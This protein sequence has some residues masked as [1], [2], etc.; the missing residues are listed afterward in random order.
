M[1]TARLVLK[2]ERDKSI[3]RGH[4]WIYSGAIASEPPKAA[5]GATVIVEDAHGQPLGL[6]AYAPASALRARMWSRNVERPIDHAFFKRCIAAALAYRRL[7]IADFDSLSAAR[8]LHAESDGLPGVVCDRY[9]GD[10][11]AWLVVQ[12][13]SAGAERWRDAIV[14]ALVEATG[15]D[16]V[17]ERSDLEARRREGLDERVGPIRG[18]APPARLDIREHGIV[19]GVDIV[20]GHKTG[21]YVDQRDNRAWVT[22]DVRGA[23]VLNCCCYTGG[24]SLVARHAG[25]RE[26]L[27]IDTSESALLHAQHNARSNGFDGDDM[28]WWREDVFTALRRLEA[29]KRQFDLVILD[30]PKF[31]PSFAHAQRAARAY[32]DLNLHAMRV[33]APDGRLATFSCSAGI[34]AALFQK[35]VAGAAFDADVAL[36]IEQ[37]LHAAPDHPVRLAF[38]EGEYLKGLVLRRIATP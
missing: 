13:S 30:P 16:N 29:E 18:R 12:L 3:R 14:D 9:Q 20:A 28:T 2:P 23:R 6:A 5:V 4:P 26:V 35:I 31:A 1:T 25:A 15:V 8:L 22:R 27:S 11:G 10:D 21:Y 17:Y 19:I 38:P 37:R 32:K 33:L 24:F 34:D 7:Q 36:V